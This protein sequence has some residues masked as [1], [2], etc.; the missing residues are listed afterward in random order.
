MQ[1]EEQWDSIFKHLFPYKEC[2]SQSKYEIPISSTS[3]NW[4]FH[5][6]AIFLAILSCTDLMS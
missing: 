4:L 1:K 6:G 2:E 3:L 5:L